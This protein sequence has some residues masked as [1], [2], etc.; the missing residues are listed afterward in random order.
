[1]EDKTY[2]NFTTPIGRLVSGSPSSFKT[3]D[4]FGE[5]LKYKSGPNIGQPKKEWSVGVAFEKDQKDVPAFMAMLKRNAAKEWPNLFD[6]NMNCLYADFADKITDGDSTQM[7]KKQKRPCD[8]EGYKG[9]WVIWFNSYNEPPCVSYRAES[10]LKPQDIKRG[11]YVRITGSMSKNTGETPGMYMNLN[12][13][14]LA[15]Y[16]PVISNVPDPR[17]AFR[18][19]EPEVMPK[20][21]N[22]KPTDDAPPPPPAPQTGVDAP[23]VM[24]KGVAYNPDDLLKQGW[25]PE[26][27]A[28]LPQV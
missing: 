21:M 15:G 16:G 24:Y 9:C 5:A 27:V 28:G 4:Q 1:M 26:Q 6:E 19:N 2:Y 12:G 25:K 8:K 18:E 7:N 23:R 3:V 14:E 11:Y 10:I 17:D 22:S 20:G 13:I